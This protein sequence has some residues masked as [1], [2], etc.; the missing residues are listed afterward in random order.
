MQRSAFVAR[1]ARLPGL[2]CAAMTR[3]GQ[4]GEQERATAQRGDSTPARP[5]HA[6][7]AYHRPVWARSADVLGE[8]LERALECELGRVRV[9]AR[10]RVAVEAMPCRIDVDGH[11]GMR[12]AD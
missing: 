6:R 9:V 4:D 3:A 10:T 5:G 2:G 12:F 11:V 7:L 1:S 8:E